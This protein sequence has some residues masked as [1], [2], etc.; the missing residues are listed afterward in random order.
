MTSHV[1]LALIGDYRAD[2]V[3]HQAIPLAVDLAAQSLNL[4]V[5]AEWLPTPELTDASMLAKYDAVWLVPG[6]PYL[7]DTGAFMAIRHARESDLPFLGSCGGFQYAVVEYARNVL[8]WEDAGHAETDTGGRL[9]IAPLSCSL[10]E[11][12]GTIVIQPE[13]RLA[14]LY[15]KNEIEEGY[16]CNYGVNADFVSELD[17][18]SLRISAHDLDGDVRAIELPEHKF[19]M[20]TLF[21]SERAALRNELS[22]MVVELLRVAS[23]RA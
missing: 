6:S 2:A 17:G 7:N 15:G 18:H 20:A 10:V 3:A 19:F 13:T 23:Q 11:K 5:T 1:R 22:P 16:H 9:V 14:T 12:T 21:Q 8:G 4:D